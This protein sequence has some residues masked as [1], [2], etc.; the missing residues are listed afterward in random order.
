MY[1]DLIELILV[2]EGVKVMGWTMLLALII[3]V[4]VEPVRV[5][6]VKP[7][8]AELIQLVKDD[9]TYGVA[10]SA[11]VGILYYLVIKVQHDIPFLQL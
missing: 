2:F 6:I 10:I 8:K 9:I 7:S 11:L 5:A 4:V 3:M 1:P